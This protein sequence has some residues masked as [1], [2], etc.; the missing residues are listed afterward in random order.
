MNIIFERFKNTNIGDRLERI[1]MDGVGKFPIFI[2][3]TINK[4]FELKIIPENSIESI[5]S[6]YIFMKKIDD[7]TLQFNYYEP[8]WEW[9]KQY[10]KDEMLDQFIYNSDLWGETPIKYP[11]FAEVL[12]KKIQFFKNIF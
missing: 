12:N 1:A 5:A 10:L 9:I 4:C 7:K 8:R 6:W 3:P 11:M 2:L